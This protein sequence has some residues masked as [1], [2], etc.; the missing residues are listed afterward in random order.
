M[1]NIRAFAFSQLLT[2]GLQVRVLF[3]EANVCIEVPVLRGSPAIGAASR[4]PRPSYFRGHLTAASLKLIIEQW[5]TAG[6][7]IPIPRR[8]SM[9]TD[10]IKLRLAGNQ[11]EGFEKMA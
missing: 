2:E 7:P 3:A 6:F 5:R 11:Y 10:G 9:P 1:A 8:R 4:H